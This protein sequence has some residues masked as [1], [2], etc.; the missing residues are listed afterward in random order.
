MSCFRSETNI[1]HHQLTF[2]E[3]KMDLTQ[4]EALI[5][6]KFTETNAKIETSTHTIQTELAVVRTEIESHATRLNKLENGIEMTAS[7]N[8]IDDLKLQIEQLKQ[9]NLR[10]NLRITGL[11]PIAFENPYE[12]IAQIDELLNVQL[13][14]SD[15]SCY[16]DKHGSSI[17]VAFVNYVHKRR[18]MDEL[19]RRESLF[20]EKLFPDVQSNSRVYANDQLS[21]YFAH[22]FQSAWTAKR[23]GLLFSATSLGGRIRVRKTANSELITIET[24]KLLNEIIATTQA[25]ELTQN[26]TKG[27]TSSQFNESS[28]ENQLIAEQSHELLQSLPKKPFI[29][30]KQHRFQAKLNNNY[31]N[32]RNSNTNNRFTQ[33][34]ARPPRNLENAHQTID[35]RR[36]S[37]E[38]ARHSV[39]KTR[40]S[41]SRRPTPPGQFVRINSYRQQRNPNKYHT[42]SNN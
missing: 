5:Q 27:S 20:A 10:N 29:H 8:Q 14:S 42:Q 2:P 31:N 17:I 19:R 36:G 15:Y 41:T 1:Q 18:V 39:N 26:L 37:L 4:L 25:Q 24:D 9:S 34:S 11:P 22:L 28:E 35:H 12:T 6:I 40:A 30:Q 23:N 13:L 38:T 32:N 21:P 3:P 16:A 33:Q 7:I